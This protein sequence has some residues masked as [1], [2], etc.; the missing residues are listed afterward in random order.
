MPEKR[1]FASIVV[2]GVASMMG[3]TGLA[4][5][6]GIAL[7]LDRMLDAVFD[8]H[9]RDRK[10]TL[11]TLCG[12]LA[13][14]LDLF[15]PH[16]EGTREAVRL[17]AQQLFVNFGPDDS[18]FVEHYE[19]NA[20][21]V[22]DDLLARWDVAALDR[23]ELE[24][25]VRRVLTCFYRRLPEQ[26]EIFADMLPHT[27]RAVL[28]KL[29]QI[30]SKIDVMSSQ[31]VGLMDRQAREFGI[32]EE[33]LIGVA[34]R[35]AEGNPDNFD[36]AL[37]G[38]ENAL[39][40]AHRQIEQSRLPTNLSAAIQAVIDEVDALN[41]E[42]KIDEGA[43]RI[44]EELAAMDAEDERRRAER[45]RLFDK[46]LAQAILDRNT[47][48]A[49]RFVVAKFDLEAPDDPAE[50]F[51]ALRAIRREWYERGRDKGLNFD[52]EVAIKL[53][54]T[55]ATRA[56]NAD[57]RGTA[58]NDLGI[59]LWTLGERESG[60]QSLTDAVNAYRLA[61]EERTRER[62]PLDWAMTQNNLGSTL[63][64]LGLRESGTQS[65]TNAVNALRLALEESTRGRVPLDWATTQNNLGNALQNL[66]ERESG[67]QSLTDAVNAYRLALEERTRERVPL[68]WA[69][70]QNNLGTALQALGERESRTQSLTDAV[71]AYRLALEEST[72]GRVPLDWAMTQNNLGNA[73][74]NLGKR[75]SGTQS[76]TDAVNAFRLALEEYTCERV[77]LNWAMTQYNLAGA[78]LLLGGRCE[79]VGML[80]EAEAAVIG[81]REV[82]V[83]EAGMVHDAPK[84]DQRLA[85]IRAAIVRLRGG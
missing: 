70:T 40:A 68:D 67:T 6:A 36:A 31:L 23:Q 3:Q 28:Q 50:R 5:F 30:E 10:R 74:R 76:L 8:R 84:H 19:M 29:G 78:L 64:T 33:M 24:R 75:E 66:G 71:N 37:R 43:A 2:L 46:G 4:A 57:E 42:G 38:L 80:E 54:C 51:E 39:E 21:T 85:D 9:E 56:S 77:P 17:A 65:L 11:K 60:T 22:T 44:D 15:V 34:R 35:Y 18:R 25:H 82:I 62:A 32:K 16:D 83:D 20:E 14:E 47:T 26:A 69:I 59:A 7:P 55:T 49:C 73:L 61:L 48:G 72:R 63:A 27:Q 12:C 13:D 1:A 41:N 45:M 81:A 79:D 58:V 52:L 53:A